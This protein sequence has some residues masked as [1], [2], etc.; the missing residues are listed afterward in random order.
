[1]P[2]FLASTLIAFVGV[3]AVIGAIAL[4]IVGLVVLAIER[5]GDRPIELSPRTFALSAIVLG[6]LIGTQALD[7]IGVAL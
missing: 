2:G 4:A 6:T 1:M 5:K 3:I 7:L